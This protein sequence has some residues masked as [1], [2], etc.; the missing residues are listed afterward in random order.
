M[1]VLSIG[2]DQ[3][4]FEEGSV[5]R[6]RAEA[7]AKA[8]GE[9]HVIVFTRRRLGAVHA[10][11]LHIYATGSWSRLLYAFD[12][13]RI[14]KRV[15]GDV[16]TT[17]DPFESGLAGT[18]AARALGV[19]LH[20]QLHTDPFSPAFVRVSNVGHRM[21]YINRCRLWLM[22][23]VLRRAARIRVVSERLKS[24]I[25]RRYH[26]RA[27]VSVLPIF[28]DLAR[29]RAI[30]HA[31]EKGHLL[32]VGRFEREKD[33]MLALETLAV[34]RAAGMDARLTMLGAGRLASA[35]KARAK[36]RGLADHIE[37]AG[38]ADP[39]PYLARAELVLATSRYEGYG[40]A[41]IEALAAGVPV[42]STDVGIAR[43]AGATITA[44]DSYMQTAAKLLTVGPPHPPPVPD[45]YPSFDDYVA[46]YAADIKACIQ[47]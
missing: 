29:F 11:P 42:L 44:R 9:L 21:S 26:P 37:L 17:Q 30:K 27:R 5:V 24:E 43:E 34:V 2:S 38:H 10:G 8:L 28:T 41:I 47:A 1:R 15:G 40:L 46:R 16:V 12:A 4:L 23:F 20:V 6:L 32:W 25:T 22:P 31:P 19:P 18:L 36:T 3:K 7:Y 35:V 14:A 39:L 13:A 45:P 33:P